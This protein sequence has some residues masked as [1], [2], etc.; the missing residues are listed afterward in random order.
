MSNSTAFDYD[1]LPIGY[2]DEIFHRCRGVQSKW[3]HL[4][5]AR[6]RDL[7]GKPERHLD[8][9]CGPGTFI[10]TLTGE[11]SSTGIDIAESQLDY[12]RKHYGTRQRQFVCVTEQNLP[13]DDSS[14]DCITV[15]E[16]IEHL[17]VEQTAALMSEVHRALRPAGRVII[18]TPNYGSV[19][20][21]VELALN[22]LGSIDY[23]A[24]H[25]NRF[26]KARFYD[27]FAQAGFKDPQISAYQFIAPF[28]AAFGW[29]VAD[30][31]NAIEPTWLTSRFGLLLV[32]LGIKSG[33]GGA[34]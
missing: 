32:G 10:G 12:A 5:F 19:W 33:N 25:I 18:T 29:R 20:P 27:L 28:A 24:Q 14:F 30:L 9:G 1:S 23:S 31:I 11:F 15:I 17:T 13:F 4:K 3:H 34:R 21:M 8:I 22:R 6:V 26:M 16:L 2:Y 7:M